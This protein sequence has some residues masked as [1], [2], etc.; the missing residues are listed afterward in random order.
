MD[1][2][3]RKLTAQDLRAEI[4]RSGLSHYII[5]ARAGIHPNRL[6]RILHGHDPLSEEL[7]QAVL[8]A[9][10]EGCCRVE[11]ALPSAVKRNGENAREHHS[12][13]KNPRAQRN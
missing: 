9:L 13:Y 10:R 2:V 4:A 12:S 1:T 7:A 6:S 8:D 5:G 11:C 3:E